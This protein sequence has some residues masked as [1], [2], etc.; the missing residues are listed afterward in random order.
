MFVY[1]LFKP[2]RT[3]HNDIT[4][5]HSPSNGNNNIV[6]TNEDSILYDLDEDTEE[7]ESDY[8]DS[9]KD[10]TVENGPMKSIIDVTEYTFKSANTFEVSDMFR[11]EKGR[12]APL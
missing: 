9:I 12:F 4:P 6:Y 10:C 5:P 7:S 8:S 3:R 2:S 11:S 1:E